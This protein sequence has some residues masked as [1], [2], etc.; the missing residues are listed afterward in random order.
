[1]DMQTSERLVS[2]RR[3]DCAVGNAHK[4]GLSIALLLL[5][6]VQAS[7]AFELDTIETEHLRLIYQAPAQS[8]LA[9]YVARS[10]ENSMAM[11]KK[12]F[13]Y[14]P[15]E[16]TTVLLTDF[17]DYGNASAT[18]LPRNT[19]MAE[20]S[21]A[22]LSF[23]TFSSVE[24]LQ[25][26][27]NHELVHI[28]NSDQATESDRRFRGLLFGKATPVARH[29]ES[30]FYTWL[31]TPRLTAPRWYFEGTAV[32]V[33]TWM[34]G[35]IGRAQGAYDEM[36]FRSMVYDD[37]HFYGRLGLVSEAVNKDFKVAANYYLYGTRFISY[38]AYIYSPQKVLDWVK[39]DEGSKR[40]YAAQFQQVFAADLDTVWQAWIDWEHEFQ[41]ANLQSIDKYPTTHYEDLPTPALGSVSRAYLDKSGT[42]MYAA[43]HYPG[44]V[45]HI[46]VLDLADGSEK[47]L[48]DIKRPM[49]YRATSLA[50]D[51]DSGTV[52]Y[53]NDNY[54]YRDLM[55]VNVAS[56]KSEM[57]LEDAR[58]GEL[59]FNASDRSLWGIRHVNG[60]ATLVRMPFPYKEWNQVHSWPFGEI[61]YDLDISPDGKLLSFSQGEPDGNQSLQVMSI[62]K[63]LQGDFTAQSSFEFGVAVPEGFVFSNDGKYL[64]GSSYYTGVSNIYRY[65]VKTGEVEAVS[66]TEVGFFRPI[67]RDDGSLIVFRYTQDGLRPTQIDA[68]PLEDVSSTQF[69]GNL[70][71]KKHPEVRDW[72]VG[73]SA[74]I[75]IEELITHRGKYKPVSSMSLEQVYPIIQ[76]YKNE[77]A[78]GLHSRFSDP[79][80]FNSLDLD[81]S[82]SPDDSFDS[83]E[84]WHGFAKYHYLGF[85]A[86]A[87][88]NYADFYDLFGPTKVS[89]KGHSLELRYDKP[90]IYDEPRRLDLEL[91]A[92]YFGNLDRVPYAQE[93]DV[94]AD[95]IYS[96]QARL[97]YT[98]VDSSLGHVDDEKGY[99]WNLV[100]GTSE[101][102][103]EYYPYVFG[104]FD[105]GFAL[106]IDN[107][108]IWLRTAG[109]TLS[110]SRDDPYGNFYFG[111]FGNNWVDH[112]SIKRYRD[113]FRLPGFDIDDFAGQSFIRP[114]LEW[115]LPPYRFRNFG[116]PGL[117]VAYARTALFTSALITNPDKS[118][119]R[120]EIYNI[121]TQIDFR[122]F[123][124]SNFKM[125][126]SVGYAVGFDDGSTNNEFM[127]SLKLMGPD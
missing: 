122:L 38:L 40:D 83:N 86:E 67:P 45:A 116:T 47:R 26:F 48:A 10:F 44:Q 30:I 8:Y 22:S 17:S 24:R 71:V 99:L 100:A 74:E 109:G 97:D 14:E 7:F 35:G 108:S 68:K 92:N 28:V 79:V 114:M 103:G 95:E 6:Q 23:E 60:I 36:V 93:I 25:T 16:K 126:L 51:P 21:P 50:Y 119:L 31:T 69:L 81:V 91:K 1:M 64:Y 115:N 53:T 18:A 13:G 37:A 61:A 2:W 127:L 75:P 110:G 106:P 87:K 123:V 85:T 121:G 3:Q 107:S 27:M 49:L 52:F 66:N 55:A 63:L 41:R 56:G 72:Q 82:Y 76:G 94:D 104:A 33:E 42:K 54:A 89:L 11:Q 62:E 20:V 112:E 77:T 34:A 120:E 12:L 65:E 58:I 88:Y 113:H 80:F 46:A 57:L 90:L 15:E 78:F 9:P 105:F 124:M 59:I 39:R 111:G 43:V 70:I 19:I 29:P 32:F 101:V 102:D 5:M 118:D 125:T 73:S 98:N 117:Y 4:S 84:E 96:V